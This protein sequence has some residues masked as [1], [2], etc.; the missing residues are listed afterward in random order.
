MRLILGSASQDT[1]L[2]ADQWVLF[3]EDG[4]FDIAPFIASG[5]DTLDAYIV[6]AGG[7]GGGGGKAF[8]SST[9]IQVHGGGAGGGGGGGS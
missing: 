6:G 1:P 8:P 7:G 4:S 2:L 5:Y 3:D 9:K